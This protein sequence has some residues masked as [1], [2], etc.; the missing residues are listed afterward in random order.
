[1]FRSCAARFEMTVLDQELR[2]RRNPHVARG[3]PA[4]LTV[5]G[6][7]VVANEGESLAVALAAAGILTLRR[8]PMG[9]GARGMFCLMGVCQECVVTVDGVPAVACL[10]PVRDGMAVTLA[11]SRGEPLSGHGV[12]S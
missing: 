11:L 4:R 7:P 1:M 8:S 12:E 5:N 9:G 3:A 2:W 6:D 10:E